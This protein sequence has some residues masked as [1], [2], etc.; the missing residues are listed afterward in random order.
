[1]FLIGYAAVEEF[2]GQISTTL[3]AGPGDGTLVMGPW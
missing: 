1:L 3:V 2:T